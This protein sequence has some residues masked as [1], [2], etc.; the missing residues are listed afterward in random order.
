MTQT[1]ASTPQPEHEE[2]TLDDVGIRDLSARDWLAVTKRAVKEMLDDNMTMIASPL[3]Y[4]SFFAVPSV[5]LAIVGLAV[6][7]GRRAVDDRH[8]R[9]APRGA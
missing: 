2:P 3:A 7:A 6:H 9:A 1:Q 8:G 5:L 4:S